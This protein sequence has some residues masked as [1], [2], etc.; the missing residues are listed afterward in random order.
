ML[1]IGRSESGVLRPVRVEQED[2]HAPDLGQPDRD[3][4]VAPRQLDGDGQRQPRRVLHPA[5]RQAAQV[6]VRV[7]MLLVA[8]GIDRLPEVA[9]AVQ[10]ADADRRQGHVTG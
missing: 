2:G 6:V 8:V 9:L 5:Q 1:V 10:E 7:V 4:Q 3:G